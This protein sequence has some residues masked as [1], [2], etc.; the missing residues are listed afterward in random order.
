[1]S[2]SRRQRREVGFYNS[3]YPG[4]ECLKDVSKLQWRT[5]RQRLQRS[6]STVPAFHV[7]GSIDGRVDHIRSHYGV[8]RD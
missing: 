5:D 3:R 7:V 6:R 4:Q 8:Y 1:M 2:R